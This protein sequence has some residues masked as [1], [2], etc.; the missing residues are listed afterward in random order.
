VAAPEALLVLNV[1][2]VP[3]V[4]PVTRHKVREHLERHGIEAPAVELALAEAVGN[5]VLHAYPDTDPGEVEVVVIV[6]DDAVEVVV[7]HSGIGLEPNPQ[8][9][10]AGFGVLLMEALA[11]RF[12]FD[13]VPGIG[14]TVRMEFDL[15]LT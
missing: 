2:A 6:D 3:E 4:L 10:R 5:V 11:D 8:L 9:Q 1:K 15:P 13:A 7:R 14:T 12:E